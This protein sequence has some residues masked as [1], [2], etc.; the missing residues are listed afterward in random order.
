[1]HREPQATVLPDSGLRDDRGEIRPGDQV[2][3][4][5]ENDVNFAHTLLDM[6]R[7]EGF[8][9]VVVVQG[10]A[11]LPF[12]RHFR[13]A[14]I[15]LDILFPDSDGW[16]V[17]ELLKQSPDTRD[18][19]VYV[20]TVVEEERERGLKQGAF[21]YLVK[22][23]SREAL[24][25][26]FAALKA[27]LAEAGAPPPEPA[28]DPE[29]A[30]LSRPQEPVLKTRPTAAPGVA[31]PAKAGSPLPQ[32]EAV[33][34]GKKVLIVDDDVRTIFALTSVLEGYGI[35]VLT[36]EGGRD[37]ID[38]LRRTPDIDLVLMDIMMPEMDGYETMRAIR[39][40]GEFAT[41]PIIAVTAKVM[42]GDREKC[43]EAGASDYIPKPV[44]PELLLSRLC[45]AVSMN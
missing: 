43:I 27:R 2:I 21:S 16:T 28:A 9:G 33:L 40:I 19:P 32:L 4:I 29:A 45:A 42:Q 30:S 35:E 39:Q 15:T 14:A 18:I 8:K 24:H 22:P 17:L 36:A 20:I 13:P 11:V 34:A 25:D 44:D 3:L 31:L 38:I 5:A 26:A 12:A 7:Q 23:I 41:L 10:A 6:V 1:V 37:G